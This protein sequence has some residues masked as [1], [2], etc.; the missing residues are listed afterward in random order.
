MLLLL[1]VVILITKL[2]VPVHSPRIS[3]SFPNL[4]L[5]KGDLITDI[6][7][8]NCIKEYS[9]VFYLF[10]SWAFLSELAMLSSLNR[11]R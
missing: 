9:E 5:H 10:F 7:F 1:F 8:E 4:Q 11:K 3:T 6:M 2:L